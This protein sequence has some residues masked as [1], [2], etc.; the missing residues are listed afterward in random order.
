M[1]CLVRISCVSLVVLVLLSIVAC[2]GSDTSTS[3]TASPPAVVL[4]SATPSQSTTP[5]PAPTVA[6][7][8]AYTRVVDGEDDPLCLINTDGTGFT[9][10]DTGAS[11]ALEA[12]WSPDGRKLAYVE[13]GAEIHW[14]T[15]ILWIINADGSGKKKLADG[16][17]PTWSPD[18]KQLAFNNFI[19]DASGGAAPLY[20]INADGTHRKNLGEI[21]I[22]AQ[23]GRDGKIRMIYD[24]QLRSVNPDGTGLARVSKLKHVNMFAISPDAK[25]LAVYQG[26]PIYR[27]VLLPA[28]GRGEPVVLLKDE[29]VPEPVKGS[30]GPRLSWSPDGTALVLSVWAMSGDA[31][32]SSLYVINADGS[33]LSVVPGE[34]HAFDSAWRPE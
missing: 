6:G 20:V 14:G 7:T 30:Q 5:L 26:Y 3:P 2:G 19:M 33:G 9:K 15:T 16:M 17:M 22:I 25:R 4:P 34:D 29:E 27:L 13:S 23:W 1:W 28:N 8:I 21:G 12:A 31:P 24:D 32:P 18:G 11:M 10:M